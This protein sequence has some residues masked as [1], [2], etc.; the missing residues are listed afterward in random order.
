MPSK[1]RSLLRAIGA[2]IFTG[3]LLMVSPIVSHAK[4]SL[5]Q[6]T[7]ETLKKDKDKGDKKPISVPEPSASVLLFVGLGM[8]GLAAS[9]MKYRKSRA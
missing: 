2:S 9:Y 6:L 7:Q 4:V 8:T 3:A 1:S 5:D